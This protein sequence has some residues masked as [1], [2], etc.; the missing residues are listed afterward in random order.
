MIKYT[1]KCSGGHQ[2]ESW[3]A[4]SAAYDALASSGELECPVCGTSEVGKALMTPGIPARQNKQAA[5]PA[6]P[7]QP[8]T[9]AAPAPDGTPQAEAVKMMRKLRELVE[10]NSDYVGPKFAEEARKIHYEES[11]AR[12]IYGEAS[13]DELAELHEDGISFYPLPALP[14]DHN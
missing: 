3:F 9:V 11:D 14:E 4:G 2:Y 10:A 8:Q 5:A 12:S 7:Q 13:K 6:T 1:L